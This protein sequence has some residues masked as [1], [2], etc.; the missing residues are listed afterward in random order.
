MMRF[1]VRSEQHW[2]AVGAM[3]FSLLFIWQATGIWRWSEA[4]DRLRERVERENDQAR[5]LRSARSHA[6]DDKDTAERLL[7]LIN[8]PSPLLHLAVVAENRPRKDAV[9]YEWRWTRNRLS[10]FFTG[11]DL[12]PLVYIE[13]YQRLPWFRDV[14]AEKQGDNRLVVHMNLNH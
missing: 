8:G 7:G 2:I 11:K 6:I 3:V 4:A 14:V 12:D 1:D 13:T 5:P 9:L 10:A